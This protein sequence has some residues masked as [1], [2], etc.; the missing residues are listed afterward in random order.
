MSGGTQIKVRV[1]EI[2]A[3]ADAIKRFRFVAVDGHPLPSFSAGAHIVVQ[4]RDGQRTI[5]NPYSLMGSYADPQ[6]Y[7]ISVLRTETS[8]GGSIFL[9]DRVSVGT[10]L[11]ISTPVNLFPAARHGRRHLLIA[12]GIGV[13]PMISLAEQLSDEN[14]PFELHY[15]ARSKS[16]AAYADALAARYGSR[17]TTYFDD[18]GESLPI[19][20]LLGTQPIGTHLYVCGPGGMI[21]WVMAAGRAAGWPSENLHFERFAAP[22]A[23]D[24]FTIRLTRSAKAIVVGPTQS[25]LEAVEEAGVDAPYLCRGGA[26]GHCETAVVSCDGTLSHNDAFLTADERAS[27][28]KIMICVSRIAGRELVLD[29]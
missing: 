7:Q 27:G 25:I 23:G 20:D 12:G 14:R 15:A 10:E 8:R 6:S 4:M 18:A 28:G 16:R 19:A 11:I 9:H 21:D 26:C 3:V 24:P 29:L 1:A 17:V 2:E 13:T 22:P 5:L